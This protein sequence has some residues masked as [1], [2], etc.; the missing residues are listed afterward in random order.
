MLNASAKADQKSLCSALLFRSEVLRETRAY[1]HQHGFAEV[2][3]PVVIDAPAIEEYI[4]APRVAAGS[5]LRSSPELEMKRLLA[6]G[7]ERIYEISPCFRADEHGRRH[8]CEFTML[9]WYMVH[10]DYLQLLDF[11]RGL[12]RHLANA[13]Q[14]P[15]TIFNPHKDWE[16][17]SVREAFRKF[18]GEDADK[19]GETE[20]LF[21]QVLVEKVEPSLPRDVPCVLIDYPIRFGAFARKKA[22]DPTLAERWEVYYNGIEL[23]NAYGELVDAEEQIRRFK[24]YA[25]KRKQCGLTEYP[26]PTEFLEAIRAGIPDSAG[27]A[28]G[29]D[30]LVMVLSGKDDIADVTFPHR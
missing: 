15:E 12:F 1:Y 21:E 29:F 10:T 7:M 18:A 16:I 11:T 24:E 6:A 23:G 27:C 8:R 19:C 26:E 22:E 17:I 3:T 9:E 30:R 20:S 2:E 13:L 5:F 14:V 28:I 4:E 25:V